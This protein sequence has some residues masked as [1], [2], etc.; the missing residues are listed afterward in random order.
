MS[1][2]DYVRQSRARTETRSIE[3]PTYRLSENPE[4]LL[5]MLG[6]LDSRGA[7]PPVSIDAALGVPAVM[8]AVGFLSR[9][10]ASLPLQAFRGGEGGEKIDGNLAM[11]LNE[12]PN[13]EVSSFEWRRHKWQQVFT[14]GR[15]MSWIERAGVKPIAIWPLDPR[16][17][18]IVRRDG[19]KYYRN[20]GR[21]YPARDVID[22][23]FMPKSDLVGHYSPIFLGRKAIAL[24]LAMNDFAGSF[25]ASGG[26]PPLALEGPLPQGAE[27]FKRAQSDIKRAIDLAKKAGTP[28]FGMP[29]GHALKAIGIEPAKGQMTEARL[30][31][32]QEVAR[33]WGLPPV[34]VQDLSKGT[35]SNTEQQDLQLVKHTLG[36]WAKAFEDELN[37]KLFGQRRRSRKVKHNLDGMQRGAF[38]DRI[39]GIARAIMTGQMTPDEGRA[40]EDRPADP[41]GAGSKLYIQGATVPLG[42]TP[43]I[44]N[45]GEPPINDNKEDGE[46]AGTQTDD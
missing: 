30:F 31:Q 45:G 27:A 15:G 35:F 22:V 32:I 8:C 19:R 1:P 20:G 29:P 41:S 39:E 40:L 13:E 14:G 7:L 17:T 43:P 10:L 12:A 36:Q 21:E 26:V 44:G 2:D 34:F 9:A 6:V 4:A 3:D 5:A 37:L 46:D 24:A 38:K 28:F 33:I 18:T 16:D 42:T 25:F 11:L 23:P